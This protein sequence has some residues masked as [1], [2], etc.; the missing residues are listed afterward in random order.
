MNTVHD[1]Q[2]TGLDFLRETASSLIEVA[3]AYRNDPDFRD[4]CDA[5]PIKALTEM[6]FPVVPDKDIRIVENT[7]EDFHMVFPPDPNVALADESLSA[8][9]GGAACIGSSGGACNSN[10][11]SSAST[12]PSTVS[13]V[14]SHSCI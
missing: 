2:R 14:S 8:V 13:S 7:A 1:E 11:V 5:D 3:D 9:A 6:G 12:I 10:C 4:R